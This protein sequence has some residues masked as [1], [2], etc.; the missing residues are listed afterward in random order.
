MP[1][2]NRSLT[3]RLT[4]LDVRTGE[5]SQSKHKLSCFYESTK[6]SGWLPD[7]NR[8]RV[9]LLVLILVFFFLAARRQIPSRRKFPRRDHSSA[10]RGLFFRFDNE[11]VC[12]DLRECRSDSGREEAQS[13]GMLMAVGRR[14]RSVPVVLF[15]T[16]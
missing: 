15:T 2:V 1:G 4:L 13:S 7:R 8:C 11:V 16:V 10:S 3:P 14:T 6:E 9:G 12:R 5:T